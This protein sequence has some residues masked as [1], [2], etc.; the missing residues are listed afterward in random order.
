MSQTSFAAP[1]FTPAPIVLRR[2]VV[3]RTASLTPH[4]R[5]VTVG[6][7]ELG[8]FHRDGLD[9]PGFA[10]PAFDDHVKLIFAPGGDIADA[11]PVQ[12]PQSIDWLP[13]EV[14]QTRDYT[15][16]AVDADSIS[17]DFVLHSCDG[18]AERG[19]AE[20]WAAAAKP[21]DELW[22]VGPKSS[23]VTP[24]D[25]DW[26]LL[27]GDE[28]AL[29]ALRRFFAERPVAGPA[30]VV[31]AVS[32]ES[33]RQ[34]LGEGPDDEVTWLIAEPGD[35]TALIDAVARVERP[36]GRPYVWAGAESR[37]LLP[38]RKFVRREL[39]ADKSNSDITGY[40]HRRT[41][42]EPSV[43][44][45]KAEPSAAGP[46]QELVDSPVSWF[47]VRAALQLGLL[48]AVDGA[49]LDRDGL[50]ASIGVDRRRLD[51]LLDLLLACGV[52][53]MDERFLASGPIGDDLLTDDH[54]RER[55]DGAEAEAALLLGDLAAALRANRSV[56][57]LRSGRTFA[58]D[59]H[60]DPEIYGELM[61]Q[62]GRLAYL[63]PSI[64]RIPDLATGRQAFA[65]PGAVVVAAGLD[66][67]S[68]TGSAAA[69]DA[70]AR[71]ERTVVV[72]GEP[73]LLGEAATAAGLA[74]REGWSTC[75]TAVLVHA[76]EYRDDAEALAVL[77]DVGAH[78]RRLV[79]VESVAAD[80]LNPHYLEESVVSSALI[81]RGLRDTDGLATLAATAGWAAAPPMALGWGVIA[82]SCERS[83]P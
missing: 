23:T 54:F 42:E 74:D 32:A 65:G 75:D 37:A 25:A 67:S 19:P 10:S 2:L 16:V 45:S 82:L 61:E 7:P 12:R 79:I 76:L 39:G 47:A 36:R 8:A 51:P 24:D 60:A 22:V 35:P 44:T 62:A 4:M 30:R 69:G 57:S 43:S 11:L 18:A 63:V 6:G 27:V 71:A 3:M 41:V 26:S 5:R 55:F 20:Q 78:A 77:R 29:P 38:V 48:D 81:G 17:F 49:R 33:A 58:D 56:P 9:L 46:R 21:G 73:A 66:G 80:A 72:D 34:P 40:W 28:T 14:R 31:V 70:V 53:V 52:L 83:A 13:S 15:P 50:A 64:A 59:A 1:R 68:D